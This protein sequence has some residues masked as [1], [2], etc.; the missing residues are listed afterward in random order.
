MCVYD[1]AGKLLYRFTNAPD[2]LYL[3]V[4]VAGTY[5]VRVDNGTTRKVT[6]VSF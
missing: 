3:P 4:A 5:L 6:V 1:V 2:T